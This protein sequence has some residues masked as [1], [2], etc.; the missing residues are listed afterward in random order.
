MNA[1]MDNLRFGLAELAEDV[2]PVDLRDRTLKTSRRLGAQRA[3]LTSALAV[4]LL[5]GGAGVALAVVDRGGSGPVV[6]GASASVTASPSHAPSPSAPPAAAFE[7]GTVYFVKGAQSPKVEVYRLDIGDCDLSLPLK[8]ASTPTKLRTI[9]QMSDSCPGNSVVVS[10]DGRHV[11]WV[12]GDESGIAGDLIISDL[13]GG[14]P[15][16]VEPNVICGGDHALV[17]S[18]DS[19]SIHIR[20]MDGTGSVGTVGAESGVYAVQQQKEWDKAVAAALGFRGTIGNGKLTVTEADGSDP[21]SISYTDPNGL[22][23]VV[24]GVSADGRYAAAGRGSGDP[25]RQL[26]VAAVLD[27]TTGKK[28]RFAVGTVDWVAFQAD[29]SMVV[30]V[31]GKPDRLYYLDAALKVTAEVTV[32]DTLGDAEPLRHVAG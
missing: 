7:P 29:G 17:W 13:A 32:P 28:V 2:K 16:Q 15:R 5:A 1:P 3:A 22:D 25:S 18:A 12:N 11:A 31:A 20:K 23:A 27:M 19:A 6:P 14:D 24:V 9:G 4:T 10:P 26:G 21:R 8:C 30:T